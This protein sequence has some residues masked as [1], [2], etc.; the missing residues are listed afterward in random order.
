MNPR[1]Q[2]RR[3]RAL[4]QL[5]R[6]KRRIAAGAPPAPEGD[7]PD[8]ATSVAGEEDPGASLDQPAPAVPGEGTPGDIAPR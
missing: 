3:A 1:S 6:V 7:R 5:D 8:L 2:Q 4:A